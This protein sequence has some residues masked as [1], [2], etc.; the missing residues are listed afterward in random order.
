MCHQLE[1]FPR[2]FG[3]LSNKTTSPANSKV[4]TNGCPISMV[5]G[6]ELLEQEDFTL[7]GPLPLVWNRTYRSSH[8]NNHGLGAGW[9]TPW[10]A[11]LDIGDDEVTYHDGEGRSIPFA[12]PDAQD[13]CRN[14]IEKLTLYCDHD[15]DDQSLYRL[16]SD[17][18]TVTTF[19]GTGTHARLSEITHH[20][21]HATDR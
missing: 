9:T 1:A 2:I 3:T 17:D 15:S 8:N 12:R 16:V 5:N 6:E 14:P 11:H 19:Y 7:P 10:F 18:N 21:G 13:G 4:C 20:A